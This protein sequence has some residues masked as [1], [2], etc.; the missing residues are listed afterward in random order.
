M[1]IFKLRCMNLECNHE[2][3]K[4][5]KY[6]NIKNIHCPICKNEDIILLPSKAGFRINGSCEAN[7]YSTVSNEPE[8]VNYNGN[9][10]QMDCFNE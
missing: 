5:C 7:G 4:I 2:F 10:G 1:P 3:E 9:P 8:T 6:D